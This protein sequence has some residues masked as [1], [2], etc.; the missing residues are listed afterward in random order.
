MTEI[1]SLL[2]QLSDKT[3]TAWEFHNQ[4]KLIYSIRREKR[5]KE[6]FELIDVIEK[7][8]CDLVS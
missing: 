8:K 7:T 6:M 2:K 1:E 3:I 5:R 4:A